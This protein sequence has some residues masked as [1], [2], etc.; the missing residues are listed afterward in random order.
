MFLDF[1]FT[2]WQLKKNTFRN[3]FCSQAGSHVS[4]HER[5]ASYFTSCWNFVAAMLWPDMAPSFTRMAK[6]II[7]RHTSRAVRNISSWG[8]FFQLTSTSPMFP[9]SKISHQK[10][11]PIHLPFKNQP[12][13]VSKYIVHD[14]EK[15]QNCWRVQTLDNFQLKKHLMWRKNIPTECE[16]YI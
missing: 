9:C 8:L 13:N 6:A 10:F 7:T 2:P 14:G 16:K 5:S 11:L 12:N 3:F 15:K 4:H 1:P